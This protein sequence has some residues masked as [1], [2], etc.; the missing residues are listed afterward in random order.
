M[1]DDPTELCSS[2]HGNTR[3]MQLASQDTAHVAEEKNYV[4][5]KG[6]VAAAFLEPARTCTRAVSSPASRISLKS[7]QDT[8]TVPNQILLLLGNLHFQ[9]M[10]LIRIT[11]F[12]LPPKAVSRHFGIMLLC[13]DGIVGGILYV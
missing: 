8:F 3:V 2:R 10:I 1:G 12:S 5:L 9:E 13:D 11:D 4:L 7:F 6:N